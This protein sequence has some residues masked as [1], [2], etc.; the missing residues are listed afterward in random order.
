M[1]WIGFQL[2]AAAGDERPIEMYLFKINTVTLGNHYKMI[3]FGFP[4][5]FYQRFLH[6]DR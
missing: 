1:G 5:P 6:V 2:L 3:G 4:L